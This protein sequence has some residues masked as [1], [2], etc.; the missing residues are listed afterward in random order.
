LVADSDPPE[1]KKAPKRFNVSNT[2]YIGGLPEHYQ[3]IPDN[4]VS[5][6]FPF[7]RS[8]WVIFLGGFNLGESLL[9]RMP[10]LKCIRLSYKSPNIN[11]CRVNS[12]TL[13]FLSWD[14][15]DALLFWMPSRVLISKKGSS[16][17]KNNFCFRLSEWN[18]L[19]DVWEIYRWTDN[20][21]TSSVKKRCT[22]KSVYASL[23][24]R[25][26][27]TSQAMPTQFTVSTTV[28]SEYRI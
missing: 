24:W 19:R 3:Q 22:T 10:Q 13:N 18:L 20:L 25:K 5:T 2:L 9:T 21:K 8:T 7:N 17:Q 11:A 27:R 1:Y 4:F 6:I 16:E 12:K 23:K 28:N 15:E 14:F 26:D